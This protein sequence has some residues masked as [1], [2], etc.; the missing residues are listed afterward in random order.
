M[1]TSQTLELNSS[2]AL[3][4]D[5]STLIGHPLYNARLELYVARTVESLQPRVAFHV[6]TNSCIQAIVRGRYKSI[7][8]FD[9]ESEDFTQP[10]AQFGSPKPGPI[11]TYDVQQVV[12]WTTADLKDLQLLL[13]A[14]SSQHVLKSTA[15]SALVWMLYALR[16]AAAQPRVLLTSPQEAR[17]VGCAVEPKSSGP[18][19]FWSRCSRAAYC[20]ASIGFYRRRKG[21]GL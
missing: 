16:F 15:P 8:V 18:S 12:D 6:S 2:A 20:S 17:A 11:T 1:P 10:H 3:A 4:F 5:L 14:G 19:R 21:H 7:S 13:F 9:P